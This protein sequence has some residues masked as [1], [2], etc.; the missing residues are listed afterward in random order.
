MIQKLVAVGDEQDCVLVQQDLDYLMKWTKDWHLDFSTEKCKTVKIGHRLQTDYKLNGVKLQEVEKEK[1]LGI[2]VVNS[3]KPSSQCA[4]AMQV[5]GLIKRNCVLNDEE[6]FRLL[7][8]GFLRPHL[9]Y[10]M[11]VWSPYLRKDIE[12]L[13]RVQCR[14][15]KL[16][17]GMK[18]KSYE[19]RLKLLGITYFKKRRV[20]GDLIQFF[21]IVKGFDLVNKDDFF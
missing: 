11:S 6:D 4:K 1:D 8:N 3:L 18:H 19:E 7:F 5:L 13:E 20:R 9:E 17:K 14:G 2:T 12:C 16:V 10:C 21:Q 15:T